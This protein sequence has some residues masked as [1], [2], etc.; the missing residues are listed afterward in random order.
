MNYP[1]WSHQSWLLQRVKLKLLKEKVG[2]GSPAQ[3]PGAQGFPF[4]KVTKPRGHC[5]WGQVLVRF[6]QD[7]LGLLSQL[8]AGAEHWEEEEEAGEGRGSTWA[9]WACV[10]ETTGATGDASSSP[11]PCYSSHKSQ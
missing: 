4:I 8:W 9:G 1:G 6:Q 11:P 2:S 5:C 7:T 3:L 10:Q